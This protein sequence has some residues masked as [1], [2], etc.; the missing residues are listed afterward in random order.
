LRSTAPEPD[1]GR[2]LREVLPRRH[3]RR[4]ARFP[5]VAPNSSQ[6]RLRLCSASSV[7]SGRKRTGLP[8]WTGSAAST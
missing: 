5:G 3:G 1:S 4:G 6:G 8:V 7:P 2:R